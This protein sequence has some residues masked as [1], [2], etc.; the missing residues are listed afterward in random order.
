MCALSTPLHKHKDQ[1]KRKKEE[2][3][4]MT[5]GRTKAKPKTLKMSKACFLKT[6]ATTQSN[7]TKMASPQEEVEKGS[8]P[9]YNDKS[10]RWKAPKTL[11]AKTVPLERG[12]GSTWIAKASISS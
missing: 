12:K 4:Q 7:Q 9:L 5:K 1:Q 10:K 8:T 6:L 11:K 2:L 3:T